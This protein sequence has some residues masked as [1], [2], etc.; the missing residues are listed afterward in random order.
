M[1]VTVR[2]A[3]VLGLCIATELISRGI[4]VRIFDS[5]GRPNSHACSWWAGGMLAPFCEAESAEPIV[6]RLG[7]EA[8][9]WW[10]KHGAII[11]KTGTLALALP[12]DHADLER[13]ASLTTE[14]Q[15]VNQSEIS[16]LESELESRFR[17]GLFYAQES[18]LNPRQALIALADGLKTKGIE[19]EISDEINTDGLIIDARGLAANDQLSDLRGVRGEMLIVKCPEVHINRTIRLLHP[20]IPLYIVP[21]GNHIYMLGA[22]MIESNSKKNV[23][24]RAAVEMLSAAYALHPGF[25]EAEIIELGADVRPAFNDNLPRLRRRGQTIYANGLYRHGYLLAPSVARMTADYL[26]TGIIPEIMD[27]HYI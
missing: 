27:E 8:E 13:F 1:T 4:N 3:G 25:A 21:R 26:E 6:M 12:R 22:T 19:I 7:L 16:H 20:R 11:H 23:T 14:Y 18:H 5:K 24:V 15:W 2:G 9:K 10:S 17:R